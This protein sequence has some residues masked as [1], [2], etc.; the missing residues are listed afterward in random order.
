MCTVIDIKCL[1]AGK[2]AGH[3]HRCS[4]GSSARRQKW[5]DTS[6]P[7]AP[8]QVQLVVQLVRLGT[9]VRM[10]SRD[11]TKYVT[12]GEIKAVY[13]S[14]NLRDTSLFEVQQRLRKKLN[15]REN[16]DSCPYVCVNVLFIAESHPKVAV[17]REEECLK[18]QPAVI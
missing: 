2:N 11:L 3:G 9:A 6:A 14:C 5:Y 18:L 1:H 8:A 15:P 13:K 7:G 17:G 12:N 10:I 4:D 16:Y